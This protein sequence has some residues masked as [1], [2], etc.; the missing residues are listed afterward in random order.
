MADMKDSDP[1]AAE[2]AEGGS[3]PDSD[4]EAPPPLE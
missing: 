4:E 1:G 3:E 2:G